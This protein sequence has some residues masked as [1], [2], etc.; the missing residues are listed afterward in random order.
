MEQEGEKQKTVYIVSEGSSEV[1]VYSQEKEA[2]AALEIEDPE[3][4][5]S[6]EEGGRFY[7]DECTRVEV[8]HNANSVYILQVVEDK[9]GESYGSETWR[10]VSD[11]KQDLIGGALAWYDNEHNREDCND[12]CKRCAKDKQSCQERFI[13]R[14]KGRG[15]SKIS[16]DFYASIY[17]VGIDVKE[18]N[19]S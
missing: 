8:R 12:A 4:I 9:G 18:K 6:L 10:S 14:L 1:F 15:Y 19:D 17:S 3:E 11:F 5:A 7:E 16:R 2:M 13:R